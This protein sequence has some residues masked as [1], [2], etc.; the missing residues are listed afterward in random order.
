MKFLR[1]IKFCTKPNL[2][3][4]EPRW[5]DFLGQFGIT[6]LTLVKRKEHVLGD[7]PSRAPQIQKM[8][9]NNIFSISAIVELPDGFVESYRDDSTFGNTYRLVNG[10]KLQRDPTSP[11]ITNALSFRALGRSSIL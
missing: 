9:V 10:E 5:L 2:S 11:C 1:I 3:R 7:T 4:G 6:K 8:S